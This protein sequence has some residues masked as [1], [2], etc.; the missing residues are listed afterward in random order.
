MKC[1]ACT[2]PTEILCSCRNAVC[3]VH[4]FVVPEKRDSSGFR[5]PTVTPERLLCLDCRQKQVT[6]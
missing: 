1:H 6:A 2:R 4:A 3:W 5:G